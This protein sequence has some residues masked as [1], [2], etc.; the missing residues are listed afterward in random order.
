MDNQVH[1][2][3]AALTISV[4]GVPAKPCCSWSE[5][6]DSILPEVLIVV[7]GGEQP[8]QCCQVVDETLPNSVR[9]FI[10]IGGKQP[11]HISSANYSST[12]LKQR[13]III[14]IRYTGLSL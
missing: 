8:A 14:S 1:V 4:L 13:K 5:E 2:H 7:S 10:G 3:I 11:Q 12:G 6:L 9:G